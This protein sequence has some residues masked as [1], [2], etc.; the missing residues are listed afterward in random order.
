M[1]NQSGN[2]GAIAIGSKTRALCDEKSKVH[3]V[4]CVGCVVC[5]QCKFRCFGEVNTKL[6]QTLD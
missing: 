4:S 6:Y 3:F 2:S 5:L 1:R